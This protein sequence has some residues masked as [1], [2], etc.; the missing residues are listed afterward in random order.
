ML[1][2]LLFIT[3]QGCGGDELV[4]GPGTQQMGEEC[5]PTGSLDCGSGTTERNGECVPNSTLACGEG[6]QN[7]GGECVPIAVTTCGE[8]TQEVDGQ[9][10][11]TALEGG[12]FLNPLVELQSVYGV[13]SHTDEVRIRL[14]DNLLF[15]CSYTFNIIDATEA[16]D[17]DVLAEG[18]RHEVQGE[19]KRPPGCKHLGWDGNYV[20]TTHLGTDR[21]PAFLSGWDI[22]DPEDP[23]Q[24]P[25]IQEP[26]VSYEGV[27]VANSNI[28]VALHDNGLGV[29]RFETGTA[30]PAFAR[31]GSLGGF[32]N[33]WGVAARG[34]DVFV[35]DLDG[36]LITVDATDPTAPA[37]LGRVVVGGNPRYVV[38]DGDYAYVATGASGVAVVDVSDLANP[39]VI[40]RAEM[41]GNAVRVAYSEGRIFVA[42][43]NDMRVYDVT[44]PSEP[45][46]VAATRIRRPYDYDEADREL[47]T[48][49]IFGV[50]AR[51]RDVFVGAW[52]NPY[53]YRLFPDRLAPNIRLPESAARLDF[54]A[55]AMGETKTLPLE[56]TNQGTAPLTLLDN[57]TVGDGF[58][59]EPR[60]ALIPPGETMELMVSF[61]PTSTVE[62]T[63]FL[64]IESDDPE[65]PVRKPYLAANSPG[66]VPGSE[67]P[68]TRATLVDGTPWTS[69]EASGNVLLLFYFATF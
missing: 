12:N 37:E 17:M 11:P 38:V 62:S 15:N 47:P 50:A 69:E 56:V 55:V 65:Y 28:F 48:H 64:H 66:V 58:S 25:T 35:A 18:L 60:Q 16:N 42:A 44:T 30:T 57:W 52:E 6:T 61:T 3:L 32:T 49:R 40:G 7:V 39:A 41:P 67:L 24:L 2:C 31:I 14:E 53:A 19:V 20:F 21:N 27:D 33:A 36:T 8:G 13:G 59:V 29:Y 4:C 43:W 9:C 63:G 26:G 22:T 10:V 1:G 5:V 54:G 23:V 46:F 51:G 68:L 34:D 45:R